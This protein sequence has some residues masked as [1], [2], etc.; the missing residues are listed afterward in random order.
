MDRQAKIII[1]AE[2]D[3]QSAGKGS[4]LAVLFQFG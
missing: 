3:A 4:H 1:R 2:I